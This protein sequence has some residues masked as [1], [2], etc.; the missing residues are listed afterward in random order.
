MKRYLE[1][2]NENIGVPFIAIKKAFRE[3]FPTNDDYEKW[4]IENANDIY[5]SQENFYSDEPQEPFVATS[6]SQVDESIMEELMS[7]LIDELGENAGFSTDYHD[8]IST[9][10]RVILMDKI[11]KW[12]EKLS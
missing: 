2:I 4:A 5:A 10:D 11:E 9:E 7:R 8:G 6:M 12:I 3:L 1:F